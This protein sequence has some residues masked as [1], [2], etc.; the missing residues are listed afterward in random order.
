MTTPDPVPLASTRPFPTSLLHD[1]LDGGLRVPTILE[2]SDEIGW[3][4][5]TTDPDELQA[6][7]TRGADTKDLLQYLAT[8]D[9]TLAV[10]QTAEHIERVAY[11]A[12]IDLATDG[13]VYAEVRF[14]PELHQQQGL[15]LPEVVAAVTAGFR[16]GARRRSGRTRHLDR[17]DPV[18]H[19]NRAPLTRDRSTGGI[20]A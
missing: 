14:A 11:E 2:L 18:R 15:P 3:R 12:A 8:F 9:H 7:F 17:G 1:H 13:V 4:L 20:R 10:M 19:A 16:R 5:P 6:W